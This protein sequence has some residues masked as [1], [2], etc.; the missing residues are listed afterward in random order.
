MLDCRTVGLPVRQIWPKTCPSSWTIG[1]VDIHA[2]FRSLD[3]LLASCRSSLP[4]R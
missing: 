3:N 2:T 1:V 4:A